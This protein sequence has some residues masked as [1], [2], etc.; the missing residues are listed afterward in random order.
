MSEEAQDRPIKLE[1]AASREVLIPDRRAELTPAQ[2]VEHKLVSLLKRATLPVSCLQTGRRRGGL[3][4]GAGQ[5]QCHR[6][7]TPFGAPGRWGQA[8]DRAIPCARR[9]LPL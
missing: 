5:R 6:G 2:M 7:P 1:P 9:A 4:H 3:S 8:S